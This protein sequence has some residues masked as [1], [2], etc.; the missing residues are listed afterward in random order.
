[1]ERKLLETKK[2]PIGIKVHRPHDILNEK[3]QGLKYFFGQ[4]ILKLSKP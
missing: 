3:S 2:V 1:M 4:K